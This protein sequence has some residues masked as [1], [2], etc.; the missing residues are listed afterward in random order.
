MF[1]KIRTLRVQQVVLG[2]HRF[3][4]FENSMSGLTHTEF[5]FVPDNFFPESVY[6]HL[7][8]SFLLSTYY[9]FLE[10]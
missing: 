3:L 2:D 10:L 8:P 6:S 7:E 1:L 5:V 4:L 9:I